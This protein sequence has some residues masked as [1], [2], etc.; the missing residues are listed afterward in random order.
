MD[1][2][3][4]LIEELRKDAGQFRMQAYEALDPAYTRFMD[5]AA[6]RAEQAAYA[7]EGLVGERDYAWSEMKNAQAYWRAETALAEAA[8]ARAAAAEASLKEL[9]EARAGWVLVPREPLPEMLGAFWRVKN[10]HH[11]HD[12]PPP[13]D[14]S[15]F[16]AYRAMI[17]A[18]SPPDTAASVSS[19]SLGEGGF[20]SAV[21]DSA[22]EGLRPFASESQRKSDGELLCEAFAETFEGGGWADAPVWN[23][24]DERQQDRWNRTAAIFLDRNQVQS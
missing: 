23:D 18:L 15:D 13:T 17:A 6:E 4:K 10:G 14:T 21:A 9:R 16:A 2:H 7:L 8:E 12:E 1:D 20:S 19:R 11:F 22:G 5:S 3:K 24:F